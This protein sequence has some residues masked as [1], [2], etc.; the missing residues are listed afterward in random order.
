MH[1][2]KVSNSDFQ[3]YIKRA[4][5]K[6]FPSGF[7][8]RHIEVKANISLPVPVSAAPY[9]SCRGFGFKEEAKKKNVKERENMRD[10]VKSMR[11]VDGRDK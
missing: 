1:F 3:K 6:T 4:L 9:S 10:K 7:R 2:A 5:K 11:D 8:N